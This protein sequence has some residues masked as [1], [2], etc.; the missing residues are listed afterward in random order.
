M[1]VATG[2]A[3][4]LVYSDTPG[5]VQP[6]YRLHASMMRSV[7]AA[8][9]DADVLLAVVDATEPPPQS[10]STAANAN[11]DG[12]NSMARSGVAHDD[13][14]E[15]NENNSDGEEVAGEES[16]AS[17]EATAAATEVA[18]LNGVSRAGYRSEE[19]KDDDF[20]LKVLSTAHQ[21]IVLALNKGERAIWLPSTCL[22]IRNS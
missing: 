21:P 13:V 15:V 3:F 5:V 10:L 2:P 14:V 16:A 6:K 1:G 19:S 18:A 7:K 4:Q 17:A 12:A 8:V 11:G 22:M 9:S 20:F